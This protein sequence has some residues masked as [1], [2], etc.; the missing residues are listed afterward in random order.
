MEKYTK[1]QLDSF[2]LESNAIE[3]VFGEE[4][5]EAALKAWEYINSKEVMT[6]AEILET[7]RIL[8]EPRDAWEDSTASVVGKAAQGAW[9]T[10]MV[11]IGINAALAARRIPE[12]ISLW[13]FLMNKIPNPDELDKISKDLHVFYEQVHPFWDGNGRTGRIFM[14]WW[15]IRHGLPL[16]IIHTGVEQ[17]MYYDWFKK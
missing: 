7:H 6:E 4:C 5:H 10:G 2:L 16:L 15:R 14:N 8:M 9:R 11:Y 13:C 17:Q 12:K 1:E 3:G